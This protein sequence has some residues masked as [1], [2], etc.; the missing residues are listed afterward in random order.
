MQDTLLPLPSST[1]LAELKG[2]TIKSAEDAE[3]TPCSLGR[4]QQTRGW[5][6]PFPITR[7]QE[8]SKV[9]PDRPCSQQQGEVGPAPPV[10]NSSSPK[11][12]SQQQGGQSQVAR[13]AC[14]RQTPFFP[15]TSTPG[16]RGERPEVD[17]G[18]QPQ[19]FGCMALSTALS[20]FP[21]CA[22][23]QWCLHLAGQCKAG[24]TPG[25]HRARCL[26]PYHLM[27]TNHCHNYC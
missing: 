2:D 21:I 6:P 5:R 3:P 13:R 26:L 25:R 12:T 24:R 10:P 27:S 23:G 14:K 1:F 16:K 7:P 15:T 9:E 19:E 18:P 20:D 8:A 22:M 4:P 11:V 17:M